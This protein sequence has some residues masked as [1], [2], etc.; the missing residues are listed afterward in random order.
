[1]ADF[2]KGKRV[3][4]TGSTGTIGR[5]LVRMLVER[6]AE[7]RS[8]SM[9]DGTGLPPG[10]HHRIFN[11]RDPHYARLALADSELVFH[12][13][14]SKGGVGI[15]KKRG[16][17]FLS[18]NTLVNFA[19][20]EAAATKK[21]KRF[22]FTSSIGVYPGDLEIFKEEHVSKGDPHESDFY[23]GSSKK[24]SELFC[25]ALREQHGLDYVTV[26]P[27]NTFGPWDTFDLETSMVVAALIKKA[28][29]GADPLEVWGDGEA[30]RDFLYSEDC[31]R[32]MLLA[33]ERGESGEAY[34]LGSGRPVKI[35]ILA[36]M[37]A[38]RAHHKPEVIFKPGPTGNQVRVLDPSK[39]RDKLGFMP[40]W[41]LSEAL[42]ETMKW[43]LTHK[44]HK[45]YTA[46]NS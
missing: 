36:Y 19:V 45:K 29:D 34:N 27:T 2:Y 30:V 18:A 3:C 38:G 8:V 12:L 25:R 43:Y 10:V 21:V 31:A 28:G 7:V 22:L 11:L 35:A 46:F 40:N 6:G 4:V 37:I 26:R 39:A 41:E 16:A 9:D 44:E 14:G 32:G 24:Y 42:D 13:A 17:D 1:M 33:M 5:P 20:L 15:G 23:G